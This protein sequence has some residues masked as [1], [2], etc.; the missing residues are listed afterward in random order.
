[1]INED[2]V[3]IKDSILNTVAI[4][5]ARRIYDFCMAK[6]DITIIGQGMDDENDT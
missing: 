5:K 4:D 6:I 1:M 2:I 3:K